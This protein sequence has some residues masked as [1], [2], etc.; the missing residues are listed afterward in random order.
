MKKGMYE[1][2]TLGALCF[3]E[4]DVIRT[5]NAPIVSS[6]DASFEGYTSDEWN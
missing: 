1:R 4:E 5:S 3:A 2:P 6:N